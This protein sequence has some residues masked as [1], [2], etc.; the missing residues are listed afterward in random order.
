MNLSAWIDHHA[1]L[2]PDKTAIRFAERDVSYAGLAEL[3][4]GLASALA[5]SGVRNGGCVAFLGFN[6]PEMLALLFACA[7]LGALFMPLNWRLAGPEHRQMLED[8][9]PA[10]LFV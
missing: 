5:A 9:P 10:L 4:D 2:T 3:I 1:G 8:C 7:R 6:R